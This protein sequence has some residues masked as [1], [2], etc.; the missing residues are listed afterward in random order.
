MVDEIMSESGEEQ[1][2]DLLFG[3]LHGVDL[4]LVGVHVAVEPDEQLAVIGFGL[5]EIDEFL[6]GHVGTVARIV[7]SGELP[8]ELQGALLVQ[9]EVVHTDLL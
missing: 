8:A 7:L 2:D 6:D 3:I 4:A 1:L 9:A 5:A